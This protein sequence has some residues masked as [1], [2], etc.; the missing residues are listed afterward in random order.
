LLSA[1]AP[2]LGQEGSWQSCCT[3]SMMASTSRPNDGGERKR[4]MN[5]GETLFVGPA[6]V[7]DDDFGDFTMKAK[8]ARAVRFE[9]LTTRHGPS[10]RYCGLVLA[11]CAQKATLE[12]LDQAGSWILSA[13]RSS[14]FP[15]LDGRKFIDDAIFH[16]DSIR[17]ETRAVFCSKVASE[18][19]DFGC[20]HF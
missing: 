3:L 16:I 1:S 6:Q 20:C 12:R 13:S 18:W 4:G 2:R 9:P 11:E 5:D 14:R 10:R 7:G 8:D 19:P 17:Q 15:G